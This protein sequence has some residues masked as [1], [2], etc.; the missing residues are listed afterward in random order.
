MNAS[1]ERVNDLPDVSSPH[2]MEKIIGT[3]RNFSR[4]AKS[5][6]Q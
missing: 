2:R 6:M 3:P 4:F 1:I 5:K